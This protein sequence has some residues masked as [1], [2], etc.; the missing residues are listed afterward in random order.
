LSKDVLCI[1]F[2]GGWTGLMDRNLGS[3]WIFNLE[4]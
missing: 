2:A 3:S 1:V 4:A